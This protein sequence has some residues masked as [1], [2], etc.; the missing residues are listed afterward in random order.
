MTLELVLALSSAVLVAW[1]LLLLPI[2][3]VQHV[4]GVRQVGRQATLHVHQC[5]LREEAADEEAHSNTPV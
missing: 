5:L 4:S 1:M 3:A 2:S